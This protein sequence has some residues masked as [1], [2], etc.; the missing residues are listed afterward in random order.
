[1]E[2]PYSFTSS[3]HFPSSFSNAVSSSLYGTPVMPTPIVTQGK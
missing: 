1:M 3:T 2:T